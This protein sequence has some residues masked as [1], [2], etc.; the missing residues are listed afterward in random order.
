[1]FGNTRNQCNIQQL[2]DRIREVFWIWEVFFGGRR[3]DARE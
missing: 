3:M 2:A 1:V